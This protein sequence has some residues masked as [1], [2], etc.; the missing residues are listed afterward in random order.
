MNGT[1][2]FTFTP[3]TN[4]NVATLAVDG[5]AT[6]HL[7][8]SYTFSSMAANHT[9]A[10]TFGQTAISIPTVSTNN[11]TKFNFDINIDTSV[12]TR[13]WQAVVNFDP[14]KLTITKSSVTEGDF[15]KNWTD[16]N[17]DTTTTAGSVTVNGTTGTL[18]IPGWAIVGTDLGGPTGSGTLCTISAT[19]KSAANDSETSLVLSGVVVSDVNGDHIPNLV[20][21]NGVGT[22]GNP[23]E[24]NAFTLPGEIG[25]STINSAAGTIGLTVAYGTN[26]SSAAAAFTA[27]ATATSVKVGS[28]SQVSGTSTNNFSSPVTYVVTARDGTTTKNWTVSVTVAPSTDANLSSLSLS[29]GSL[30]PSFTSGTVS[31]TANVPNHVPSLNVTP[32]ASQ[33]QAGIQVN[34]FTVNSGTA[35]SDISLNVGLNTIN[36]LVTAADGTTTKTYTVTVTRS[37]QHCGR[38]YSLQSAPG[39]RYR[40]HRQQCWYHRSY[41]FRC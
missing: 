38:D 10:V 14:N 1:Q 35:S 24:I 17:N 21:T 6:S 36:I 2:T 3:S 29:S 22:I 5:T 15:L 28:T 34:G 16:G 37:C 23:A 25:A 26:I 11:G 9:L 19:P 39:S 20:I 30:G 12:A 7:A 40:C 18:T 31:Y 4:Y 33:G 27:S 32:T 13:G 8:T 41:S